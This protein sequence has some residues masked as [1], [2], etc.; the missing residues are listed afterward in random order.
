LGV[1]AQC[2]G[3]RLAEIRSFKPYN[4]QAFHKRSWFGM[5]YRPATLAETGRKGTGLAGE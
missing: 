4:L 3:V 2:L 1:E 5:N